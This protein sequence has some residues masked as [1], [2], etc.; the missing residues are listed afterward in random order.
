MESFTKEVLQH[1]RSWADSMIQND[2]F[3]FSDMC[4]GQT[5]KILWIGCSDSRVASDTITKTCP[6]EI[7]THRNIAN[8]VH[9][10]DENILS[11]I[12]YSVSVLGVQDIVVSGHTYCGGVDASMDSE[13]ISGPISNWLKPIVELYNQ[14][15]DEIDALPTSEERNLVLGELSVKQAVDTVNSLDIIKSARKSGK[16]INVHG[17]MFHMENGRLRDL[18]VTKSE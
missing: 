3:C 4:T 18:K 15:K 17:W 7:F 9:P 6:G 10:D 14:N 8:T 1:N 16:T 13:N 2:H 5:P 12:Q 11:V